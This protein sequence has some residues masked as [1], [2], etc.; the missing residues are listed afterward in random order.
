[1]DTETIK[2]VGAIIGLVGGLITLGERIMSFRTKY[3]ERKR[4]YLRK[5]FENVLPLTRRHPLSLTPIFLA[6]Q[7]ILTVIAAALLINFVSLA[8]STRLT[9]ILYLDMTGTAVA[10]LLL[11]PWY[12]AM[13]GLLSNGL[14]NWVLYPG[15]NADYVVFPWAIVNIFGGLLWGQFGRTESF[16]RFMATKNAGLSRQVVYLLKFGVLG[17]AIMAIPGTGVEFA[18]GKQGIL[19]LDPEVATA[20]DKLLAGSIANVR[21][22][23][24]PLFGSSTSDSIAH[25]VVAW[26]QNTVRYIPDKTLSFAIAI[27]VIKAGFPLF[28]RELIHARVNAARSIP[29]LLDPALLIVLLL[30]Y[31]AAML[32]STRYGPHSYWSLWATPILIACVGMIFEFVRRRDTATGARGRQDRES[33]YKRSRELLPRDG[34]ARPGP[35]F[36]LACLAASLVFVLVL[37]LLV[38]N[39]L[40]IAF[41]FFCL[42][43]GFQLVLHLYSVALSQNLAVRLEK[44]QESRRNVPRTG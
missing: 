11:G 3:Q 34:A 6:K 31:T 17:A 28:E 25:W 15:Q 22:S 16:T 41:N 5:G 10:A 1:M 18:L 9:S 26:A 43:Y 40:R 23:L 24:L 33:L 32:S 38:V 2:E 44:E 42:V 13:A 21:E 4:R 7:E 29:G 30:P 27:V 12:G 14:V 36:A 19:A 39:Y 8:L 20:L 35:N 37:P